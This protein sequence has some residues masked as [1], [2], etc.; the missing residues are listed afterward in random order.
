MLYEATMRILDKSIVTEP[1]IMVITAGFGLFC[2]LVM[3]KVLHS[4]PGGDD[5]HGHGGNIMHQCSGHGH[6]HGGNGHTHDHHG[7]SHGPS[8]NKSKKG[9]AKIHEKRTI[10]K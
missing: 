9:K 10:T 4:T 5:G 7:H 1:L 2:N 6:G 3:A 8:P